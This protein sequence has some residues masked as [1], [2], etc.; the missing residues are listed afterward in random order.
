MINN[1]LN[2][3]FKRSCFAASFSACSPAAKGKNS[4]MLM[5][6]S[7]ATGAASK[8]RCLS[9]AH[10]LMT[11]QTSS[12]VNALRST[13]ALASCFFGVNLIGGNPLKPPSKFG[14]DISTAAVRCRMREAAK[15]DLESCF[16]V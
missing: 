10:T 2:T 4:P 6:S 9:I 11:T 12:K 16:R 14:V 8:G 3:Y 15:V 1:Q 5:C 13:F 7:R